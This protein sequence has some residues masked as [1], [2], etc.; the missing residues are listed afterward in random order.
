MKV[1]ESRIIIR[2]DNWLYLFKLCFLLQHSFRLNELD[3]LHSAL[4]VCNKTK[5]IGGHVVTKSGLIAG[6]GPWKHQVHFVSTASF[7]IIKR[8][9]IFNFTEESNFTDKSVVC[10]CVIWSGLWLTSFIFSLRKKLRHGTSFYFC[11]E[12][13]SV[14]FFLTETKYC[15]WIVFACY[16]LLSSRGWETD[17]FW[18]VS[19]DRTITAN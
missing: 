10:V 7:T 9:I 11:C 14:F 5:W 12:L 2:L 6:R 15:N 13:I 8:R 19:P 3:F 16:M 4:I 18:N 1:W 17:V